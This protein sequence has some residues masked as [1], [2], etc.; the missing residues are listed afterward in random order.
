MHLLIKLLKGTRE[1]V[2]EGAEDV[3][4]QELGMVQTFN[5]STGMV[6]SEP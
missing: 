6:A 4:V 1:D 3:N 5:K 2:G